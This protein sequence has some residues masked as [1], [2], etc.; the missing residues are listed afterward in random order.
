[1][2][3]LLC[4]CQ[5]VMSAVVLLI[6][7]I[8]FTD[9]PQPYPTWPTVGPVPVNPELVVPG[10]LGVVTILETARDSVAVSSVLL[11]ILG[12]VNLWLSATSLHALYTSSGGGVFF[13]G[14]FTLISGIALSVAVVVRESIL[15][16]RST[17]F[18]FLE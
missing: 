13:G 14:F 8:M 16:G 4:P 3:A 9:L 11:A 10:T 7:T 17:G 2:R 1:M 5:V 6:A 15:K 18:N 12:V